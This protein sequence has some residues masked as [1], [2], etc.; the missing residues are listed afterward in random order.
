MGPVMRQRRPYMASK[1]TKQKKRTPKEKRVRGRP[2]TIVMCQGRES[3]GLK[4]YAPT[5]TVRGY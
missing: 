3:I 2:T 4:I 5:P 1:P